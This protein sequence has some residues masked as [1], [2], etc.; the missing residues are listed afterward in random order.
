MGHS[1]DPD[2]F[3]EILDNKLWPVVG[4]DT[5][6][7]SW[8]FFL[9][10]LQNDFNIWFGHL[11]SDLPMDNRAT[12][13]IQETAQVVESATDVEVRNIHVPVVNHGRNVNYRPVTTLSDR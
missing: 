12:T 3:L 6:T 10:S 11:L 8:I 5:R 2:E 9:G 13:A 7:G 1:G 4:N